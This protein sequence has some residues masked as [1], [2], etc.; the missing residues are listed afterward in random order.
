MHARVKTMLREIVHFAGCHKSATKLQKSGNSYDDN[1]HLATAMF[2]KINFSHPREDVGTLFRFLKCGELM[3]DMPKFMAA[4]NGG[5][6]DGSAD[7]SVDGIDDSST[8]QAI[9]QAQKE[10]PER[11]RKANEALV[12]Q[13]ARIKKLRLAEQ[14]VRL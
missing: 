4:A 2:N 14:A 10:R 7:Q 9:A 8:V 3:R 1:I 11:R 12:A 13:Q 5:S 6:L